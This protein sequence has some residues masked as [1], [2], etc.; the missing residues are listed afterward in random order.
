[1]TEGE[2]VSTEKAHLW[3]SYRSVVHTEPRKCGGSEPTARYPW[4]PESAM[5]WD[6]ACG[7]CLPGG[8]PVASPPEEVTP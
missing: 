8:L 7:R 6:R 2:R 1:M 5:V 3:V 4:S